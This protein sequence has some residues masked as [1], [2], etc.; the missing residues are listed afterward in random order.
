MNSVH[1]DFK[2]ASDHILVGD[3][4]TIMPRILHGLTSS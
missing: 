3:A 4:K 2:T 1:Q